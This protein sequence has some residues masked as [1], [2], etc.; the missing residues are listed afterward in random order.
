MKIQCFQHLRVVGSI[1]VFGVVWLKAANGK[2]EI[3]SAKSSEVAPQRRF[4]SNLFTGQ[5]VRSFWN[6]ITFWRLGWYAHGP[7]QTR[8]RFRISYLGAVPSN[9]SGGL[10]V[11]SVYEGGLLMTLDLIRRSSPAT[12]E[13]TS[14]RVRFGFYN[15]REF[16]AILLGT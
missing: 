3:D 13:A 7:F 5:R 12:K 2:S 14:T 8:C 1:I 11:C 15:G 4:T 9:L 16:S 6:R 10:K